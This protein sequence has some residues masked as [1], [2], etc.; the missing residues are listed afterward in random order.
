MTDVQGLILDVEAGVVAAAALFWMVMR[1]V[2][3]R[4]KD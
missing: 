2:G 3:F 1:V 4:K